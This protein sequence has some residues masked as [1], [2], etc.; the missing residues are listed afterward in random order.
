MSSVVFI[1]LTAIH[2]Y[3][4]LHCLRRDATYSDRSI[5]KLIEGG[6][7]GGGGGFCI[8]LS[9]SAQI[10]RPDY[11]YLRQKDPKV[12]ILSITKPTLLSHRTSF[13]HLSNQ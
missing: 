1:R 4:S 8:A 7:G 12:E 2:P 6:G 5:R 10:P 13:T 9:L 3:V 11:P